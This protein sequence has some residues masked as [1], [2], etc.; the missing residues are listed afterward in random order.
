MFTA[1]F[2]NDYGYLSACALA[3]LALGG[4]AR[5]FTRRLGKPFGL[6]WGLLAATLTGVLGVA[7]MGSGPASRQCVVNHNLAEPFHATQGLWNL[8]MTVPLGF[9][10]LFAV[11]RLLPVLAGIV[12]LP[13]AIEFTQA[14]ADGL[15][16]VCDSADVEMNVIGGLVGLAIATAVLARRDALNWKAG[17][18]ATAITS[19]AIV[20]LGVGAA[21]PMVALNHID[22]TGLTAAGSEQRRAVSAKV[23]EAF[24]DHYELGDVYEQPCVGSSCKTVVFNL[25]SRDEGHPEAFSSGSLSWP[26]KEHFNVLLVDSAQPSVMGF[27]VPGAGKPATAGEAYEIAK[28]YMQGHYSWAKGAFNHKTYPVGEKAELGWMTSYRWVHDDVLMPRML[29]IQVSRDG[30]ISQ[31]DVTLGPTEVHLPAVKLDATQA[32]AAV[33]EALIAQNRANQGGDASRAQMVMLYQIEGLT[34]KAAQRD[35]SWRSEW[36]VNVA[37]RD[38]SQNADSEPDMW[39]V[40]AAGGQVYDGT[41]APVSAD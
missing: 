17:A 19:V 5:V 20:L 40:D 1:T 25:L 22:G 18:K 32:E 37:L 28:E 16:R 9:F 6:W 21:H 29:D 39:K 30:E 2:Q 4:A 11:R 8:A 13:W 26:N 33:L 24:G 14:T 41:N 12:L 10:A 3:A 15:G 23:E 34:L 27:P 35:G 38:E 7:F 36:L 31:V